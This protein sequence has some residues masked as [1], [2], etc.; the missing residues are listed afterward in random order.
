MLHFLQ[1]VRL[2]N[3]LNMSSLW[4]ALIR[5]LSSRPILFSSTPITPTKRQA[6]RQMSTWTP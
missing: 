4:V 3:T 5:C 2:N 1:K 6:C